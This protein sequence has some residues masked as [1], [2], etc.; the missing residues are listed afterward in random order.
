MRETA[1]R[2]GCMLLL[3]I[4]WSGVAGA[5][6]LNPCLLTPAELA[7][8]LGHE[9]QAGRAERDPLGTPMCIYETKGEIG[10][11]FLLLVYPRGWDAK[12]YANRLSLAEGSGIRVAQKFNGIGAA[13][14]FVDGVGGALDGTRYVEL[15]GF[16]QAGKR[17]VQPEEA[18]TLLKLAL[19]R[20]P[21]T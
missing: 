15:S 8:V 12:R 11:R 14:F 9:P 13:A 4:V 21:A 5:A 1:L 7:P 19:S 6:P 20:L 16:K 17:P 2:R 10:K 18:A 3:G